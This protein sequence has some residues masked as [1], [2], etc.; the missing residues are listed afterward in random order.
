MTFVFTIYTLY[1]VCT[2]TSRCIQGAAAKVDTIAEQ[3]L[4]LVKRARQ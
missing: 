2:I 4:R 1:C 3:Q